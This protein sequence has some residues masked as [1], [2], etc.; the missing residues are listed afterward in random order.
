LFP[1]ILTDGPG[2]CF[3]H[4]R[5]EEEDGVGHD[6]V[7]INGHHCRDEGHGDSDTLGGGVESPDLQIKMKKNV[8]ID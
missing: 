1:H 8:N 7:V 5:E 3:L 2:Q 4:G 6:D